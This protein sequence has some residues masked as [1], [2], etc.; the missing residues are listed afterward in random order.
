MSD[1]AITVPESGSVA[2]AV[3]NTAETRRQ[4]ALLETDALQKAIFN[5]ANFSCIAT[6]ATGVIQL[7]NVGAERMLGYAADEVVNKMTP[8]DISDPNELLARAKALSAELDAPISPG[9]EAMVFKASRGIEDIYD[10]TYVRKDGSRLPAAVSVTALRSAQDVIIG[11]LLIGTDNTDR[12]QALALEQRYRRLFESAKDGILILDAETGRVVDANPFIT[13]LLGY[14]LDEV[15]DKYIWDLGF[16]RNIAANKE[17]FLELQQQDYVRYEDLPLENAQGKQVHVEF[18]S[19]VYLVG[20]ERVIQCNI[21]DITERT[22]AES[23]RR[24]LSLA[25]EQSVASIIITNVDAV[26]EYVNEA[27]F[28]VT[29]YSREEVIGQNPRILQTGKTLPETYRAMWAALANGDP[30][31]GELYNRTK[32][33]REYVEYAIITPLRQPDGSISHYVAVKE[34]ITETKRLEIELEGHRLHLEDLVA[35]RTAE[36]VAARMQ[37]EAANRA[38]ST[39]LANMS[40]EIRTPMS[41]I[42]GMAHLLRRGGVTLLQAERLD[43][44]DT[45]AEHL[46]SVINDILDVSKIEAGKF[47]L[48]TAPVAISSIVANVISILT[49]QVKAK[50]I[51]LLIE[52]EFLPDHLTGDPMRL[53]QALLN[54]AANAIKFTEHGSVTLRTLKKHE[55]PDLVT[56]RF[57]VQ[58]TGV[59][60]SAEAVQ[61]LFTAFEQADNSNSRKYGGTG[62]GLVI[63]R[64]L[65]ELMGGESGV[66]STP[67]VGSTFWFTADLKKGVRPALTRLGHPVEAEA[68]LRQHHAGSRILVVDDE[69]LNREI[70]SMLLTDVGL[71]AD[72]AMDGEEAVRFAESTAYAA[73]LMDMQMPSLNGLDATRRIRELPGHRET[74]IIAMTANA[75]AG[76][77]VK[78]IEA[79]MNEFLSKPF[80]PEAFFDIVLRALNRPDR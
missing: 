48:E 3:D 1:P 50:G 79:G 69:P 61:R 60:I 11:Y 74:P 35:E 59:G 67:G 37:A 30:W 43:K 73:I 41:G 47:E 14:S 6:D 15:K 21:R 2:G 29:G 70:A 75:F 27:F 12:Q 62:L 53:Q 78:C 80:D 18:V 34:D 56:V 39:F 26:I 10:L 66:E 57:E 22:A 16:F 64:R 33:G 45:A 40:H 77:K 32:D 36:L 13:D 7:F 17:K 72:I 51:R 55:T 71:I 5:S 4:V 9:F 25:V 68:Y 8:A 54:Y 63:T 42:L 58:D 52:T 38:K 31:R 44:I 46:L 28:K 23:E 65:A 76:D 24:K 19:N 49:D 20:R